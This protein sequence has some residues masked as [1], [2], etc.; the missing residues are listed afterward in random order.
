MFAIC[1]EPPGRTIGYLLQYANDTNIERVSQN[2]HPGRLRHPSHRKPHPVLKSRSGRNLAAS[3]RVTWKSWIWCMSHSKC[4]TKTCR[5]RKT[6]GFGTPEVG[7]M[8]LNKSLSGGARLVETGGEWLNV[9]QNSCW[10]VGSKG[11]EICQRNDLRLMAGLLFRRN[12]GVPPCSRSCGGEPFAGLGAKARWA[13]GS[14]VYTTRARIGYP[15]S[16]GF[17]WS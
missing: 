4:G 1:T 14:S 9:N 16:P 12:M 13:L 7:E 2:E 3:W 17:I 5:L 8:G 11:V 10:V 6:L 15:S